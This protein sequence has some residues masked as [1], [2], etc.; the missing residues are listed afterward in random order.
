MSLE[1]V[2][3]GVPEIELG[4]PSTTA[5]PA[6]N[7]V[8]LIASAAPEEEAGNFLNNDIQSPLV[9]GREYYFAVALV[10][11]ASSGN[12]GLSIGP[13]SEVAGPVTI[14]SGERIKLRVA[15]G[16]LPSGFDE[17][18]AMAV[19]MRKGS[20]S[21]YQLAG[22]GYCNDGASD[23]ETLVMAEPLTAATAFSLATLQ[24]G[25]SDRDLGD[26]NPVRNIY[27]LV[28]TSTGDVTINFN[29]TNAQVDP[30][31]GPAYNVAT[32]RG[33]GLSFSVLSN[34]LLQVIKAAAGNYGK[35]TANSGET[36]EIG[37]RG[38]A[39]ASA[40]L[41]GTRPIRLQ[42]PADAN[43]PGELTVYLGNLP[44]NQA[45]ISLAFSKSRP[46]PV[47]F[48]LDPAVQDTL[49]KNQHNVI[50]YRRY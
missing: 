15:N 41:S 28:P 13:A 2:R 9:V 42:M 11:Y 14:S 25:T 31:N 34:V 20:A 4:R 30:N 32:T 21:T 6:M 46:A 24:S 40:K 10:G 8:T 17:C 38:L 48:T 50:S 35:V 44:N 22:Y 36:L 33:E 49:L 39:T 12:G 29:T 7:G 23:F 43:G 37:Q 18:I 19:F 1:S 45:A 3:I 47:N 5:C 26:R 27:D 16:S